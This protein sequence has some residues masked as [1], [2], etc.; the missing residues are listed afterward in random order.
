[1]RRAWLAQSLAS[2]PSSSPLHAPA[3]RKRKFS[4][5]INFIAVKIHSSLHFC[6]KYRVPELLRSRDGGLLWRGMGSAGGERD[7]INE[8]VASSRRKCSVIRTEWDEECW[9]P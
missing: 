9:A 6:K 2:R 7:D 5:S 3:C 1:M 8:L 4:V